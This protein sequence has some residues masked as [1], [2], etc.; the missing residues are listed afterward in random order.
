MDKVAVAI[1]K[2]KGCKL[3]GVVQI[4]AK[5][6]QAGGSYSILNEGELPQECNLAVSVHKNG[7]RK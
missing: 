2:L 5:L 4:P 3:S 6:I 7:N 1:E